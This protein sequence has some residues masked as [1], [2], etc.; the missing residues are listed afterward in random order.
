MN[1]TKILSEQE[2]NKIIEFIESS[3]IKLGLGTHEDWD[4][5]TRILYWLKSRPNSGWMYNYYFQ[6]LLKYVEHFPEEIKN[7]LLGYSL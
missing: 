1:I 6:T 2:I 7:K 4:N 5:F 3:N